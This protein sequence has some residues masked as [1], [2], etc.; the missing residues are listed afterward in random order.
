MNG[1][2][3]GMDGKMA[4]NTYVGR[5]YVGEDGKKTGKNQKDRIFHREWKDLVSGCQL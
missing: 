4:K 5:Y 2:Y 1:R 3:L